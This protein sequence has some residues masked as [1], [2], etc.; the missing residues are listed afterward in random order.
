[1]PGVRLAER[2]VYLT[3][4]RNSLDRR[5]A[6]IHLTGTLSTVLE[7]SLMTYP[8]FLRLTVLGFYLNFQSVK[9]QQGLIFSKDD[10]ICIPGFIFL[11]NFLIKEV[12]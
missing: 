3:A 6:L 2:I 4:W 11:N 1:M 7:R 8:S 10:K 5:M 9:L 12:G